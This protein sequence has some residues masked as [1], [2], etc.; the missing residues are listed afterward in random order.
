MVQAWYQGGLSVFDFTNASAPKEIAYFD[1][2]P[3]TPDRLTL[4]GFWSAY[5]YNGHIYGSEIGRGLDILSLIPSADLTQNEI[6]AAKTYSVAGFNPQLQTRMTWPASYALARAY[7]DQ[8]IRS[9]GVTGSQS[10]R[11]R[12]A[13]ARAESLNATERRG[14][15]PILATQI[16]RMVSG[17]RDAAK[18]RL[19]AAAVR[20]LAAQ[21]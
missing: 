16:D 18:V 8:L 12:A 2:G 5:W 3:I 13:L 9:R 20:E 6:D 14:M 19:L 7:T 21:Q 11:I 15:L 10:N 17:S 1:R 4:A